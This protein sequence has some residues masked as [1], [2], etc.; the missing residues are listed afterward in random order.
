MKA[1]VVNHPLTQSNPEARKKQTLP[2]QSKTAE[3]ESRVLLAQL[4]NFQNK[5]SETTLPQA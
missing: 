1:R 4:R 5:A 3:P 2:V